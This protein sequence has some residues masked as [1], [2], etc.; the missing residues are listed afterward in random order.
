MHQIRDQNDFNRH[1]DY[2]HYNPVKH[3]LCE[4]AELWPCSTL[5]RYIKS[6]V[7]P[8]DWAVGDLDFSDDGFGE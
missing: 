5:H 8:S 1:M 2:I 3:G 6:G 7:Y 4:C